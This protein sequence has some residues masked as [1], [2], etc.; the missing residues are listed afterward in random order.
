[1]H[2]LV[3]DL[4]WTYENKMNREKSILMQLIR[5]LVELEDSSEVITQNGEHRGQQ[6]EKMKE[7]VKTWR[8]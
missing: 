7:Q 2:K 6:M 1:M 8:I 5:E 4:K 3:K